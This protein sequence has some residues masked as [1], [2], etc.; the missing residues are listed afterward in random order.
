MTINACASVKEAESDESR[1]DRK[2]LQV[3]DRVKAKIERL[4]VQEFSIAAEA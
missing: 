1:D 3:G 4:G 2:Y